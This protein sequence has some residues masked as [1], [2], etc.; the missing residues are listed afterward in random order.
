LQ[1]LFNRHFEDAYSD[2]GIPVLQRTK[3]GTYTLAQIVG[4]CPE[5]QYLLLQVT[6]GL[7][8]NVDNLMIDL[9]RQLQ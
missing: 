5:H 3:L 1:V 9:E 7:Q 6:L 4:P 2:P 8:R